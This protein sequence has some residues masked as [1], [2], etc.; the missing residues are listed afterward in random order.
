MITIET[1]KA[2]LKIE[3]FD[4]RT[5]RLKMVPAM[6]ALQPPPADARI[7]A[8]LAL[9]YPDGDTISII[10]VKRPDHLRNHPGQ[11]AFP[12]GR[13]DEGETLVETA[14]RETYE[15]IGVTADQIEIIGQ[16]D[17]IYIV[18]SNF[19][20]HPFVGWAPQQPEYHP[21]P[22]EVAEILDVP[23]RYFQDPKNISS[24][25]RQF[26]GRSFTIPH[27]QYQGHIIWGGTSTFIIELADRLKQIM[28]GG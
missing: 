2:A 5:S 13:Q 6:R 22:D 4:I 18:P 21:S 25:E 10:L 17:P 3:E 28:P 8:V 15:E 26:S 16:L 12:G 24:T 1:L 7:G 19:H 20:V 9:F 14:L 27:F 11:I 23:I